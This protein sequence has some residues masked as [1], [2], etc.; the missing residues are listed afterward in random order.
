MRDTKFHK[1]CSQ[2]CDTHLERYSFS[3]ERDFHFW[4]NLQARDCMHALKITLSMLQHSTR[5][6]WHEDCHHQLKVCKY[7]RQG[8]LE[9]GQYSWAIILH[10][11]WIA[12]HSSLFQNGF[13][14]FLL[15]WRDFL[16]PLPRQ[17]LVHIVC[18][19]WVSLLAPDVILTTNVQ[20]LKNS[21]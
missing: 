17:L 15:C 20:A 21:W 8:K 4:C 11:V 12:T 13:T 19:I 18:P 7:L 1:R 9:F 5:T 3:T 14:M 10:F 16:L 6:L 2:H